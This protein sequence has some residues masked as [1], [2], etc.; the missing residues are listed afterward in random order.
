MSLV[1]RVRF[2]EFSD[3]W[4]PK[5]L[6]D[7]SIKRIKKNK[8]KKI[9]D[10]LTNSA[11]DGVVLQREF[12]DKDIANKENLDTY[13]IVNK[14]DFVYNPR[15]SSLAPVGPL[16]RSH[17]E[18]GVMSPLYTVFEVKELNLEY[19]EQ[20]FKSSKWHKHM[21]EIANY[22]ARSDRMNIKNDDLFQMP[23]HIPSLAEQKEIASFLGVID[24][25]IDLLQKKENLLK[26]YKQCVLQKIF[27]QEIRFKQDD[28]SEF[29][30]WVE[31]KLGE[32]LKEEKNKSLENNQHQVLS[33]TKDNIVLQKDY[34]NKE[35]AS[36]NNIG[37]KILRKNQLVFSPQN[38]WLGNININHKYEIGIVSPSYKV[39]NLDR[40]ID[41]TFAIYF[42]KLP[43]MMHQYEMA[44]EQ[45]ASIVRRNLNMELFDSITFNLPSIEEQKLIAGF[46]TAI[47]EKI[48]ITT[49][50]LEKTRQYK[51][52]LLQQLF[53]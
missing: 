33:S 37:Y 42:F 50:Q 34:F 22:G 38:I 43:S 2:K 18:I 52:A 29:P 15:I 19:L 5:V 17:F 26:K 31:K 48:D 12:F 27:N 6:K 1:P 7:F 8:D 40:C 35:V 32:I 44:S 13:Y 24:D 51:T 45:G 11:I 46:L 10:V 4:E 30:A 39:Y 20:Y 21:Y 36:S 47:D 23:I 25:K 49:K 53:I 16:N 41:V 3:D 28:G 14:N 9:V